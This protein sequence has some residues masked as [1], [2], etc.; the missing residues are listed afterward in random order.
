MSTE[1]VSEAEILIASVIK[2]VGKRVF[3]KTVEQMCKH[4]EKSAPAAQR[5]KQAVPAECMCSARKKGE[6]TGIKAGKH[7]LYDAVRCE[8]KE[9]NSETHLCAVHTNMVARKGVLPFGLHSDPLTEE[10][11]KVFGEL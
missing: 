8:R 2:S 4:P 9:V 3:L 5:V 11:K 10:M 7:V 1:H 6:R